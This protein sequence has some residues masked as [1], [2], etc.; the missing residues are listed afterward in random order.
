MLFRD[1]IGHEDIKQRLIKSANDNHIPHAL[2]F[3]G[4]S[5]LGKL[6]LALAFADRKS[7][8]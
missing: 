2:L 7:V 4:I 3:S 5:G 1:I 8:V 6:P